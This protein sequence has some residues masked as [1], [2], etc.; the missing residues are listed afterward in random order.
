MN[1]NV[2]IILRSIAAVI[3]GYVLSALSSIYLTYGLVNL[4]YIND[5]VAVLSASMLSYIVFFALFIA[6]FAVSNIAKW[7]I[8]LILLIAVAVLFLPLVDVL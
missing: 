6:S 5:G 8:F 2:D 1:K 4:L 7:L 3:G